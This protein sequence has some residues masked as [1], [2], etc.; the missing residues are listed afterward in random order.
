MLITQLKDK[1]TIVSLAAGRK[2]LFI[3]CHG[4]QGS[5]FS[6]KRSC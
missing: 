1:E 4:M 5:S 2:F 6:G 3:N